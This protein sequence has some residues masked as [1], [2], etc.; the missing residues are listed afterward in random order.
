VVLTWIVLGAIAAMFVTGIVCAWRARPVRVPG[1]DDGEMAYLR[2]LNVV[3]ES[4]DFGG[5]VGQQIP[6][7]GDA[8]R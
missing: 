6:G 8:D 5:H 7:R 4:H 2:G 1:S 3:N